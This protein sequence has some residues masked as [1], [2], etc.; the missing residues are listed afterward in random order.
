MKCYQKNIDVGLWHSLGRVLDARKAAEPGVQCPWGFF[1]T[2]N[3]VFII[4][5][6][7]EGS[8][9]ITGQGLGMGTWRPGAPLCWVGVYE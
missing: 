6:M 2:N 3:V 1:L 8:V 9:F 5:G 7:E 4:T